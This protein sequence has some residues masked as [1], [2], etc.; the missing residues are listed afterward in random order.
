MRGRSEEILP[1]EVT[2]KLAEAMEKPLDMKPVEQKEPDPI[3][4]VGDV[5][6]RS[7]D[8]AATLLLSQLV[9]SVRD[10]AFELA[11]I[12]LKI[13]RWQ[14]VLGAVLSQF[15]S[16]NLQAPSIDPSWRQ[17]EVAVG[18][19]TCG[20]E[21]CRK[22]FTPKR[23]GEVYCSPLCGAKARKKEIDRINKMKAEELNFRKKVE[24]AQMGVKSV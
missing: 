12:T 14:L 16:G 24:A 23:F 15:E 4:V 6:S 3:Q 22:G 17:V 21:E 10:F 20:L 8:E 9:P 2:E 19:S 1:N 7:L 18:K 13:P 11:E 5:Y